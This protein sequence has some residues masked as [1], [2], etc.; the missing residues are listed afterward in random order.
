MAGSLILRELSRGNR[1]VQSS[2]HLKPVCKLVV[3]GARYNDIGPVVNQGMIPTPKEH[4]LIHQTM[5]EADPDKPMLIF[6]PSRT[7]LDDFS[8]A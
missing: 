1:G 5:P 8:V 4:G 7:Q 6:K 3:L 2:A